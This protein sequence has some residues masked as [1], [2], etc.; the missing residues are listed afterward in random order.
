MPSSA[1]IMDCSKLYLCFFLL[2][3]VIL[4]TL[5]L[6]EPQVPCFF[7]FGDSLVDNGNNNYRETTAK[8]NFFPYGIDFPAGPTGRFTNGRNIADIIG[9]LI[10]GDIISLNEQLSNHEVAV[11][12]IAEILGSESAAKQHLSA[13]IY[14]I[15]MGSNDYLGNYL[16]QFYALT[17]PYTPQQFAALLIAQYSKQLQTLY[18]SGARKVAVFGLGLL[19]CLPQ[20]LAMYPTNGSACVDS[21][22]NAV[23]LFNNR[24]KPLIDDLNSNLPDAQFIYIN[25]T[26]IS[27][28]DPS[29][30]GIR[31]VNAPCCV[32]RRTTGQCAPNQ[33][34][35]SNRNEYAFW[36][37][38]HPTE[39]L[40]FV[41]ASRAYNATL[42]SDAYPVDIRR[43]VQQ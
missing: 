38:F 30:I 25:I 11:S 20:E 21:I 43:L 13:C 10:F 1:Q 28:G 23:Q 8:V 18:N 41:M 12:R 16:P 36:D 9:R 15:G 32:V 29:V 6:G 7:I 39:I 34:P 22:N 33:V 27:S 31:V 17:T 5:V 26:G 4:Q 2:P 3:L 37:N 35:C 24:L 40:N 42:P 14:S 19:G